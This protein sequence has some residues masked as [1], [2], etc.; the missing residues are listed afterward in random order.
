MFQ[1]ARDIGPYKAPPN[2]VVPTVNMHPMWTVGLRH[3]ANINVD[4]QEETGVIFTFI[5]SVVCV[6]YLCPVAELIGTSAER[7][8]PLS[9]VLAMILCLVEGRSYGS[10]IR[11]QCTGCT[12]SD[13]APEDAGRRS[14]VT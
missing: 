5:N 10:C 9:V 2:V 6:A 12:S 11:V 14:S 8:H 4:E 1:F 3:R 13:R 7:R